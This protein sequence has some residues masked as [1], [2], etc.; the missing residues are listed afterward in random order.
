[1]AAKKL[2]QRCGP[3]HPEHPQGYCQE[4]LFGWTDPPYCNCPPDAKAFPTALPAPSSGEEK[5]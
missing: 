3:A 4:L 2:C 5:G 1:M